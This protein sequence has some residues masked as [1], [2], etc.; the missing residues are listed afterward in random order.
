MAAG[1]YW[2]NSMYWKRTSVLV[3]LF[4]DSCCAFVKECPLK[5]AEGVCTV[6]RLILSNV[7]LVRRDSMMNKLSLENSWKAFPMFTCSNI[8]QLTTTTNALNILHQSASFVRPTL[9]VLP[10]G[11]SPY[12]EGSRFKLLSA[13]DFIYF[14]LLLSLW[15]SLRALI[16]CFLRSVLWLLTAFCVLDERLTCM[17]LSWQK[18][19]SLRREMDRGERPTDKEGGKEKRA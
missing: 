19:W 16:M 18:V 5:S 14:I 12:W 15:I 6:T 2:D 13:P 11:L 10:P 9:D 3:L 17:V 1:R 8:V 7:G 4:S